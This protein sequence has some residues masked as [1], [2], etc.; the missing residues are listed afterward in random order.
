MSE[1]NRDRE[2]GRIFPH[3]Q[4]TLTLKHEFVDSNGDTHLLSDPLVVQYISIIIMDRF[5]TISLVVNYMLEKM[6]REIL[7]REGL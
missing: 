5:E 1:I 6:K 7:R 4:Y 3:E 2:E